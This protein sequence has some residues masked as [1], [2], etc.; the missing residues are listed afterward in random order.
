VISMKHSKYLTLALIFVSS[1]LG[2]TGRSFGGNQEARAG[3]V[4]AEDLRE[5]SSKMQIAFPPSTRALNIMRVTGGPD[6]A[7]Y[8]KVEID[9]NDL[10]ALIRNSPFASAELRSDRRYVL[11]ERSLSWWDPEGVNNYKSGQV[12]LPDAKYLNILLDLDSNER[13]P[14]Y[15]QWGET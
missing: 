15:L 10:D 6:D 7:I 5:C 1:S 3:A 14:I 9:R 2:C 4:T 12:S 13:I 11:K 8:L